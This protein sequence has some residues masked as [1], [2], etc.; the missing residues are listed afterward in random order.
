MEILL[1]FYARHGTKPTPLYSIALGYSRSHAEAG[2]GA[3]QDF[4]AGNAIAY[5]RTYVPGNRQ[6]AAEITVVDKHRMDADKSQVID[7]VHLRLRNPAFQIVIPGTPLEGA[8]EGPI[9]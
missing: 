9:G 6:P 3:R 5:N 1:E 8:C 4:R 2:G 7:H